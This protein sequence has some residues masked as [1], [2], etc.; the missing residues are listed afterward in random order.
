MARK[1]QPLEAKYHKAALLYTTLKL[2]PSLSISLSNAMTSHRFTKAESEDPAL[3]KRVQRIA[4]Q[5]E[6]RE[7]AR[8]AILAAAKQLSIRGCTTASPSKSTE[9][10]KSSDEEGNKRKRA[11]VSHSRVKKIRSSPLSLIHI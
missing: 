2:L 6:T 5:T 1:A 3:Q 4:A 9:S 8:E 7:A 11:N 10:S